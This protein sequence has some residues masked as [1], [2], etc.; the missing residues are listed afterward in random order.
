[1][2]LID[3]V[4]PQDIVIINGKQYRIE[5]KQEKHDTRPASMVLSLSDIEEEYEINDVL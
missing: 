5:Q 1:M 3:D 2:P 4:N